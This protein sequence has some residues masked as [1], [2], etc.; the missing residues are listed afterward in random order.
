MPYKKNHKKIPGSGMQKGQK[1]AKVQAW[2]AMQEKITNGLTEKAIEEM[3]KLTG[4][5]FLDQYAKILEFFKPKLTRSNVDLTSGG[6][7][8][9]FKPIEWV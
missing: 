5:D 3:E 9:N 7:P 2:D 6:E 1:S 4:K 8:I